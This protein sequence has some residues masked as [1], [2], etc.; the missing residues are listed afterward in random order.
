MKPSNGSQLELDLSERSEANS[1]KLANDRLD[2]VI[3]FEDALA[4]QKETS[5]E[6]A[7]NRIIAS[8]QKRTSG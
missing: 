5:R 3:K 7:I 6:E 8:L 4:F 1:P 2:N